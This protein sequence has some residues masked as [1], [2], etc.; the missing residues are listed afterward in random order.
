MRFGVLRAGSLAVALAA[1]LALSG[2]NRNRPEPACPAGFI[3]SDAAKVTRFRDGPGRDLTDVLFQANVQDILIQ[4]NHER[5]VAVVDLQ[6]AITV[7]RGPADRGRSVDLPY[8][9]AILDPDGQITTKQ[10]FKVHF[11]FND[12]RTHLGCVIGGKNSCDADE[13]EPRVPLSDKLTNYRILVGF[14]LTPEELAWNRTQ[15]AKEQPQ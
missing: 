6:I 12:N 15:A 4:C 13:P 14:Q 5:K 7:D 10:E 3:P 11:D 8:F 2:C 9:V 1:V